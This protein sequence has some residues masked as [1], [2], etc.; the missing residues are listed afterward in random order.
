MK[1]GRILLGVGFLLITISG[2]AQDYAFKVLA[3]KGSNEYKSSEGWQ[4]I[5]TGVSLKVGDE[6][7]ISENAYLGLVYKTGKPLELKKAGSYKVTDLATQVGTGTSVLNKYTDFILSSNSAEA[8]KNR[9]SATGAVHRGEPTSLNVYL[10][11]P[12]NAGVFGKMMIVEWETP[13]SGGPYTVMVKDIFED[14]IAKFETPE[15]A[16]RIDLND[17]KYP[18]LAS[19]SALI[20]EVASKADAKTKSEGK[21]V[22]KLD[23]ATL[24]RVKKAYADVSA[25]L[26]DETGF[27]K[28]IQAGFYE[29]NG[30]LIDALTSYEEAIRLAPDVDDFKLAR[31]EFLYRNKLAVQ[32]Q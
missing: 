23:P 24:D 18:K 26:Q 28:F 17:A 11:A 8:K 15:T 16:L 4:P 32:K 31:D 14:E 22:K 12:Q 25:D 1:K 19:E 10:P 20:I 9:L 3:N 13:K 6:L 21:V 7:K 29:Q 30:L 5:R 2:F 27:S